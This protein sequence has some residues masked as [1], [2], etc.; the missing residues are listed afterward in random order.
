MFLQSMNF[1]KFI[2]GPHQSMVR[3]FP[4]GTNTSA[5]VAFYDLPCKLQLGESCLSDEFQIS[6]YEFCLIYTA[7]KIIIHYYRVSPKL[8]CVASS[9]AVWHNLQVYSSAWRPQWPIINAVEFLVPFWLFF[10]EVCTRNTLQCC[11][12]CF[13]LRMCLCLILT[14]KCCLLSLFGQNQSNE[15]LVY[16]FF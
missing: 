9:F 7:Y 12:I 3:K 6:L 4:L 8:I 5:R 15:K 2:I 1:F 16:F 11:I 10:S 13:R 14:C